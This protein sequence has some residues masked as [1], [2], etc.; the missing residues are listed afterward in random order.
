MQHEWTRGAALALFKNGILLDQQCAV[1]VGQPNKGQGTMGA[2][3]LV[4]V[5]VSS[6]A[7]TT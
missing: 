7:E 4:A 6:Y 5:G 3:V 1:K 2:R